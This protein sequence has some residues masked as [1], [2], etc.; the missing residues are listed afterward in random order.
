MLNYFF[1]WLRLSLSWKFSCNLLSFFG[2]LLVTI[3]SRFF[4]L[5]NFWASLPFLDFTSFFPAYKKHTHCFISTYKLSHYVRKYDDLLHFQS[6]AHDCAQP[7][8]TNSSQ[9]T[10]GPHNCKEITGTL[11]NISSDTA[12]TPNTKSVLLTMWT[13]VGYVLLN[14]TKESQS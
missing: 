6:P 14:A 2:F 12:L 4:F 8:Q 11:A 3:P 5:C 7:V 1:L 9:P 10:T 13:K